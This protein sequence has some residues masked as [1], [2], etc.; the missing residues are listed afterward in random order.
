MVSAD[1]LFVIKNI[2]WDGIYREGL[3]IWPWYILK[4]I[5]WPDLQTLLVD[6]HIIVNIYVNILLKTTATSFYWK[7]K[8]VHNKILEQGLFVL[9]SPY[10]FRQVFVHCFMSNLMT[11]KKAGGYFSRDF[12]FVAPFMATNKWTVLV[13]QWSVKYA[14]NSPMFQKGRGKEEDEESWQMQSVLLCKQTWI[15]NI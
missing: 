3:K 2:I 12:P 10:R 9:R 15:G 11:C 1:L 14:P 7:Q 8:L 6:K 13:D 4:N 5:P